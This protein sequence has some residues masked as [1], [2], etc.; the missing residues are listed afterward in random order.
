MIIIFPV[1]VPSSY[2]YLLWRNKAKINKPVEEREKDQ[3][4]MAI[5]FLFDPY[6]PE[7]W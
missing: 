7:F 5:G 4:L 3:K 6:K 1:G 2:F